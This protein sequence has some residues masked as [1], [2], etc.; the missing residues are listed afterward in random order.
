MTWGAIVV[1]AGRGTRFGRPKQL[2]DLGGTPLVAWCIRTFAGMPE[3]ADVVVVTE[4]EWIPEMR[5]IAKEAAGN[6]FSAVVAGGATRQESVAAGLATLP[7]RTQFVLVHDGARPFVRASDV[8]AAMREVRPGRASFLAVPVV[9][10]IK[11]VDPANGMVT[12]TF[13]RSMLWAAQTPQLAT[14]DDLTRAHRE[15]GGTRDATDDA[16]LLERIGVGVVAVRSNAANFKV[17]VPEDLAR[18]Q[19]ML[20]AEKV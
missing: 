7:E 18:A 20:R 16:A 10:T 1:A 6:A 12:Q 4:T 19:A 11:A 13:D 2:V 17:T 9:D 3:I 14:R 15:A 5:A 8:R